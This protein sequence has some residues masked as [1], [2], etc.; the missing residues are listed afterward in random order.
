MTFCRKFLGGGPTTAKVIPYELPEIVNDLQELADFEWEAFLLKRV[1]Q[2]LEELPLEVVTRCGYK[3]EY[4]SQVPGEQMSRQNRDGGGV[5][6]QDSIGLSFSGDGA[7]TEIV[8]GG[9][10]DRAGFAHGMKVIGVNNKT[11]SRERLLDA[12]AESVNRHKIEFLLVE[13]EDLRTVV[14]EYSGGP[15][16]LE[17][18]RDPSK[19]DLL[20][21]ILKPAADDQRPSPPRSPKPMLPHLA[22]PEATS[23]IKPRSRSR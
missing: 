2:P 15:R 4:S 12:L 11:F 21:E 6:A 13:G 3:I 7:I 9:I 22:R 8:A 1:A 10:G 19:P 18:V 20:A 14:L 17:L 16:Y 5:S 23:A